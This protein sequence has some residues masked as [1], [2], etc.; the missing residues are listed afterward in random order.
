MLNQMQDYSLLQ[1]APGILG[2][3]KQ[4]ITDQ[5]DDILNEPV[6]SSEISFYVG[7]EFQ[8]AIDNLGKVGGGHMPNEFT[9]TSDGGIVL[10][11]WQSHNN[12]ELEFEIVCDIVITEPDNSIPSTT[13]PFPRQYRVN[14][15]QQWIRIDNLFPGT[16][17]RFRIR[18][19]DESGWG[20]WSPSI[21]GYTPDFPLL[22]GFTDRLVKDRLVKIPLPCDGLYRIVAH[23][24]KAADGEKKKGGKGAIIEAQFLLNKGDHLEI[25]VGGMSQKKGPSSGGAGGSFLGLNG[26]QDLLIAAG[27]G[28]GT[29]GY[30]DQDVDGMDA[31][32]D[33][34]GSSGTGDQWA[35]GGNSG[36]AGKDA[37]QNGSCWGFGGAGHYENSTSAQSFVAGGMGG[38]GGGFG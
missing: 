13:N 19:C 33:H 26:R 5:N 28:G 31:S 16:K 38:D 18:S 37:M 2:Q 17:Y 34:N 24:A 7:P 15:K 9:C 36:R 14:G 6:V 8:Q 11:T 30:D 20:W 12:D 27:G 3:M 25:L 21:F 22:I 10:L 35:G 32:L 29:R 4:H 1:R 23:G